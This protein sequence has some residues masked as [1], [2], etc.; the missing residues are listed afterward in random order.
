M[1]SDKIHSALSDLAIEHKYNAEYGKITVSMGVFTTMCQ[2]DI[3][4]FEIYD[5]ADKALYT[6]KENGR[7]QT[8]F[9]QR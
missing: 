3:S 6:S 8:T 5:S 4:K 9:A 1:L 7:S 2:H